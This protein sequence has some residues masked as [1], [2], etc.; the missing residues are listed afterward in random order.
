MGMGSKDA[1]AAVIGTF[2]VN[3][4]PYPERAMY[5]WVTST[6]SQD[7][8][9]NV[10][11][12]DRLVGFCRENKVTTVF[13]DMYQYVGSTNGS[14]AKYERL[15]RTIREL[16]RS[17][18]E[19]YAL[20]GNT[21]WSIPATQSWVQANITDKIQAFNGGGA[22]EENFDG[23]HLDVEYWTDAGQTATDG[24]TGLCDLIK[25]M[26]SSLGLPVGCFASFYLM[27]STGSRAS[28][29][30]N[31]K[32][33]QDGVH[34]LDVADHVA[35]GSYRNTAYYNSTDGV[36]GHVGLSQPW[37][38]YASSSGRKIYIAC[39]TTDVSPAYTT[40][41]GLAK[42]YM[43]QELRKTLLELPGNCNLGF[44]VHSYDGWRVMT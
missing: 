2:L 36:L 40:Y 39:E 35:V 41:F 13:L 4:A 27:D 24:L 5:A 22:K 23:F 25:T 16:H 42:S 26:K 14:D 18:I 29:T 7:P 20:A 11:V 43:E 9:D 38:D 1:E 34:L 44:A 21:D 31:G 17:G 6:A 30:Y 19:V 15:R 37:Y 12:Q 3:T 32:T 10:Y 33:A 28:V 8:L